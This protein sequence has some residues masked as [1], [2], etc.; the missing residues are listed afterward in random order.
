MF[1]NLATLTIKLGLFFL[2]IV[3]AIAILHSE[4]ISSAVYLNKSILILI[5]LFLEFFV[6]LIYI[7]IF[8]EKPIKN[9]ETSVKFFLLGDNSNSEKYMKN[10]INPHINYIIQFFQRVIFSLKNIKDEFLHGK[11]IKGEVSLAKEI[12]EKMLGKKMID[13]PSLNIVMRSKPAGEVGG[14]SYDIIKS[15][16]SQNYYIYVGDATGHGVGAGFIMTMV[17]TLIEGFIKNYESGADILVKTNQVLKPRLK[18]N[19]LMSL[20]LV[21]WDEEEKR[22][23]M[24][25]AGH[26]YLMIY[27]Q[28]LKKTFKIKSGGVALGMVK[29]ISKILK[30][31]EIKID[32]GDI[33]VLYSDG[34]TEAINKPT[35]D[36][37]EMLFGEDRLMEAIQSAP[38]VP[39][40]GYKT[41]ISVYKNISIALSRFMGY[42]HTQLDDVTL[43]VIQ[44]KPENYNPEKDFKKEID[45]QFITEWKW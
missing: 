17:N 22:V 1:K 3:G 2:L 33:I 25:G 20:L 26:E 39:G 38:E 7:N 12:Q 15:D 9:L 45:D 10:T 30:E 42:K 18:A 32:R 8:Y 43:G 41:S 14:D 6:L 29:D 40:E 13:V 37:K 4:N 19:L 44:Y 5:I 34:V 27:K 11:E 31:V 28:K 36:G 35:K 21:R 23:F 16:N 24:T